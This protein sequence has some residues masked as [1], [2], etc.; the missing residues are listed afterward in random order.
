MSTKRKLQ[1]TN[2]NV[3]VQQ[4][5]YCSVANHE[6]GSARTRMLHCNNTDIAVQHLATIWEYTKQTCL[7]RKFLQCNKGDTAVQQTTNV[8]VQER[9]CC[10]AANTDTAV[11]HMATACGYTKQVMRISTPRLRVRF[12]IAH[13]LGLDGLFSQDA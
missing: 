12:H 3:A 5:S 9:K 4:R 1:C 10:T 2:G 7:N 13:F 11:Q 8:A 6:C